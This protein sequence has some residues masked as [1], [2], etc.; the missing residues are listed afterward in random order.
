MPLVDPL[1]ALYMDIEMWARGRLVA[2]NLNWY[3][4]WIIIWF[5]RFKLYTW[6]F[7]LCPIYR[8]RLSVAPNDDLSRYVPMCA[9]GGLDIGSPDTPPEDAPAVAA[10]RKGDNG[11]PLERT[12]NQ[13]LSDYMLCNLMKRKTISIYF[14]LSY[15]Y[16]DSTK[17]L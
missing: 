2:S 15:S 4:F 6:H 9:G 1:Q 8:Y 10:Y 14:I 3:K 5:I 17:T 13:S 12:W 16:N 7:N 11:E